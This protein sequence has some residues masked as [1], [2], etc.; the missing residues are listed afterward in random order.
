MNAE[1]HAHLRTDMQVYTQNLSSENPVI[2]VILSLI[3]YL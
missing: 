1:W 2:T 3:L